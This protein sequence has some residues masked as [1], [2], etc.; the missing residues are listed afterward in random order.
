MLHLVERWPEPGTHSYIPLLQKR[1]C[2]ERRETNNSCDKVCTKRPGCSV[3]N[4]LGW[5]G[6]VSRLLVGALNGPSAATQSGAL[7]VQLIRTDPGT[8]RSSLA[9]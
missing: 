2:D 5:R 4:T 1:P 3:Q 6:V 7:L 9:I 8:Y